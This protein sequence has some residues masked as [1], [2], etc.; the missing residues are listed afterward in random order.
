M[1]VVVV[2]EYIIILIIIIVVLIE[3]A[4]AR[5]CQTVQLESLLFLESSFLHHKVM[6]RQIE[7]V[8]AVL[9]FLWPAQ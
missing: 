9:F 1:V 4:P 2:V 8:V 6:G 5:F 3:T 7:L